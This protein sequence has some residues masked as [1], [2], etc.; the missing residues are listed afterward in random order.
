MSPHPPPR[1]D[2][3]LWRFSSRSSVLPPG[4]S[5]PWGVW[6]WRF[7]VRID[8]YLETIRFFCLFLFCAPRDKTRG[9]GGGRGELI[10]NIALIPVVIPIKSILACIKGVIL[11]A[12]LKLAK[13]S[14]KRASLNTRHRRACLS[15]PLPPPPVAHAFTRLTKGEKQQTPV[16]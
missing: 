11:D 12:S 3:T 14:A 10:F 16:M 1:S 7:P 13:A 8:Y 6:E 2:G 4:S 5:Q 15:L 9:R